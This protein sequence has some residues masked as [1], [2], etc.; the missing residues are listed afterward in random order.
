MFL[1]ILTKARIYVQFDTIYIVISNFPVRFYPRVQ[2]GL[3][4]VFFPYNSPI[5]LNIVTFPS[6]LH[7]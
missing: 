6:I 4:N 7:V 5:K 3:L 2:A 1:P